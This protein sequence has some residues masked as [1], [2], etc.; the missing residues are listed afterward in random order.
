MRLNKEAI[1]EFKDIYYEEFG[2]RISDEKAQEMGA[3]LISLFKII[4]R[5]LPK[6]DNSKH[7]NQNNKDPESV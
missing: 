5:P 2:E 4:Y 6:A 1:K 7:S 3:N